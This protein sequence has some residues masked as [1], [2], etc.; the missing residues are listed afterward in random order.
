M[1]LASLCSKISRFDKPLFTAF[2][3]DHRLRPGSTE[4][5]NSVARNLKKLGML[6][7]SLISKLIYRLFPGIRSQIL[8][9]DWGRVGDSNKLSNLETLARRL[10][11]Q[12]LARACADEKI[13]NLLVA[14]HGDDQAETVMSRIHA[15]YLGVGLRGIRPKAPIPECHGMYGVSQ[16]GH[17]RSLLVR[18]E[19]SN[20]GSP[21]KISIQSGGVVIHRPLLD[22]SKVELIATCQAAQVKWHEDVTNV[23]KTLTLR[24]AIRSLLQSDALPK[25][26][27][28]TRLKSLAEDKASHLQLC[29][30]AA[31]DMYNACHVELDPRSSIVTFQLPPGIETWLNDQLNPQLVAALLMRKLLSLSEDLSRLPLRHLF[32]SVEYVFPYLFRNEKSTSKGIHIGG[33]TLTCAEMIEP[34]EPENESNIDKHAASTRTVYIVFPRPPPKPETYSQILVVGGDEHSRSS[35]GRWSNMVLFF[36]R[37]WIRLRYYPFNLPPGTTMLVRFLTKEDLINI[38]ADGF[39]SENVRWL[40]KLLKV[41]APGTARF[42]LPVIVERSESVGDDG[43]KDIEETVWALPSISWNHQGFRRWNEKRDDRNPWRY[44]CDY[45]SVEFETTES[46]NIKARVKSLK[47]LVKTGSK[48]PLA[49]RI[50]ETEGSAEEL[51]HAQQEDMPDHTR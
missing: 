17:P 12:A 24:N 45:K 51:E 34:K 31:T 26:L 44:T 10:R 3:V 41:H 38:R 2:I 43:A 18:K 35:S 47:A 21:V 7:N 46:H 33:V 36:D 29:E 48:P 32:S 19:M 30:N 13:Y 4:E 1:A 40:E 39:S 22:F 37:W 9:L 11:F 16:S 25:A 8:T 27:S 14:H 28:S 20:S 5:A 49:L 6:I 23:D 42:S 15:G 50:P